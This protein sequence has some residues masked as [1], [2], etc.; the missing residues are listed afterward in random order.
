MTNKNTGCNT[1]NM[2]LHPL[3]HAKITAI[4]RYFRGELELLKFCLRKYVDELKVQMA[5]RFMPRPL[6]SSVP[7]PLPSY[8]RGLEAG[9][10]YK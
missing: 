7:W 5:P 1:R 6:P 8:L 10:A 2:E 9:L 3:E 4:P